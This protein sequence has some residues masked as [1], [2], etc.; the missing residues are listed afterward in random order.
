MPGTR[1]GGR[2]R[3]VSAARRTSR[4]RSR[5]LDLIEVNPATFWLRGGHADVSVRDRQA[6]RGQY[7]IRLQSVVAL[8]SGMLGRYVP[9]YDVTGSRSTGLVSIL[10]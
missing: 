5:R 9:R 1:H 8:A 3:R 4:R 7:G 2:G 6:K 10:S